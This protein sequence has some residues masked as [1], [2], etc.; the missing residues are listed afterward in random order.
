MQDVKSTNKLYYNLEMKK[1]NVKL[2]TLNT[3]HSKYYCCIDPANFYSVRWVTPPLKDCKF[4][5]NETCH[6]EFVIII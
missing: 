6:V 1:N 2:F 4:R 3:C 5:A